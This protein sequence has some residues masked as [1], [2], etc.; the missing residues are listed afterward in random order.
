MQPTLAALAMSWHRHLLAS[1]K[2]PRTIKTYLAA[3]DALSRSYSLREAS[4][5]SKR[6]LQGFVA[7]RLVTVKPA[8]VSVQFRALQQFWKWALEE[9][10]VSVSPMLAMRP[11]IVHPRS[12]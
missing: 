6:E 11:P 2:S 1:N 12:G 9:G 4:S 7:D 10:E 8:T 5:L 3:V